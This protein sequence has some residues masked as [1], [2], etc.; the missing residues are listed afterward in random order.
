MND[1]RGTAAFAAAAVLVAVAA[2]VASGQQRHWVYFTDKGGA[3]DV[4]SAVAALPETYDPRATWRRQMRRTD[5]GLFDER[6]LPVRADYADSVTIAGARIRTQ[7]RWL[8]AVSVEADPAQLAAIAELPHVARV[9]PV[10]AGRRAARPSE[11]TTT[12]ATGYGDRAFYGL[13]EAQLSQMNLP[14]LHALGHTGSGVI[15]AVLDTGFRR[16]HDAFHTPGHPLH[17]IAEHD[18]INNDANADIDATDDSEQHRHGTWI[19]ST[20]G[21]YAPD[22]YVGGA[23]NASFV[24]CKTEDVTSETPIEE[25]NYVAGLEFAELHGA[26]MTTSSLGYIDW[27]TQADLDGVT[28]VTTIAV[29]IAN[30]NGVHCITAAGNE[31]NDGDPATSTIIAPADAPRVITCGAV[32][33]NG[34]IAGFSSTGPTAD[35]RVKPEVLACG[36][37]TSVISSRNTTDYGAVSGTSLSTPLVAATVACLVG[38]HPDWSVDRMRGALTRSASDWVQNGATDPLFIR[39]FG[40]VNALSA[41]QAPCPSDWNHDGGVDGDDVIAF[42]GA[43]DAGNAD[44][45]ASG[46]TDGDDVIEFFSS[47]DSG[48]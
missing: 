21:A 19:L 34:F 32:D 11:T 25:D 46:G 14:A 33:I 12:P 4:A 10:R 15:I 31:G 8:N 24:L 27:Y 9:T 45:N 28:A 6:D 2:G 40:I 43:W 17:V 13:A 16:D 42:F 23:Y 18:F 30:A 7:S 39:G 5:P 38:A 48:C 36:V 1:Q 29:N 37:N 26:D 47:W 44:Y 41:L 20:I 22:V 35:G 3:A